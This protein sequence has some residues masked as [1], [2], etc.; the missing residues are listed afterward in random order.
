MMN[1]AQFNTIQ[2]NETFV[3]PPIVVYEPVKH[4]L[5]K[6]YDRDNVY[7][8]TISEALMDYTIT[9][10]INGGSGPLTIILKVKPEDLSADIVLNG[11]IK[12]YSQNHWRED[13][14]LI[15]YGYITSIDPIIRSGEQQTQI[16]LL[17]AISKLQNDFLQQ[18]GEYLAFE[19]ENKDIDTH[20]REIIDNYRD[21]INDTYGDYDPCMMDDT[22]N[23]FTDTNFVED[24]SSY[25]RIPYRYFNSKHLGA[26]KEISKFLPRNLGTAY[27]YFYLDNGYIDG[28]G[29]E[30]KSRFHLKTV[31]ATADHTLQINKHIT[32]LEVRKNI[33]GVINTVYFWNERG[34]SGE[35]V[36]MTAKD[37]TSQTTYD[38]IAD[39]ITDSKVTTRTQANLLSEAKLKGAKDEKVEM[40]CIV[41]EVNYDILAL[42][43]GQIINIRDFQTSF[44]SDYDNK[45]MITKMLLTPRE[46]T[47]ELAVPRPDLTTQV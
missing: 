19:V 22:A 17:G 15:Y 1:Q 12:I 39:R 6:L 44:F 36:L 2:F 34:V 25:G 43:V 46:A 23:Y 35:K 9:N 8:R 31:S 5:F 20:I 27:W 3:I 21:S 10:I 28:T 38:K 40:T 33:E 32:S 7:V 14:R 37:S 45:L 11:K 29:T 30:Y 18:T 24:T 47:L 4:T 16:T 41:S 42:K 26:I 13:P